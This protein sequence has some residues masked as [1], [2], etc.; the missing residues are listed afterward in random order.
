MNAFSRSFANSTSMAKKVVACSVA[1][2]LVASMSYF[3]LWGAPQAVADDTTVEVR[4][5]IAQDNVEVMVGDKKFTSQTKESYQASTSSDLNFTIEA[6]NSDTEFAVSYV[7]EA[8]AT[9]PEAQTMGSKQPGSGLVTTE[10]SENES[11]ASD[12]ELSAASSGVNMISS[13][14]SLVYAEEDIEP[15]AETAAILQ[16][17][18]TLESDAEIKAAPLTETTEQELVEDDETPMASSASD[19]I[20]KDD[21]GE[22][23]V[24]HAKVIISQGK[25]YTVA[26]AD[27]QKAAEEGSL[28]VVTIAATDSAVGNVGD[29]SQLESLLMSEND[30]TAVLSCDIVGKK[31]I[32]INGTKTLDLNGYTITGEEVSELFKVGVDAE[33]TITDAR[34]TAS[35]VERVDLRSEEASSKL[36]NPSTVPDTF[37]DY[38]GRKAV[39]DAERH[40]LTYYVT[41]SYLDR[42]AKGQS[43]E[44]LFEHVLDLSYA[45][46]IE[47]ENT[48]SLVKVEGGTL[49]IEGGRLTQAEGDHVVATK[50]GVVSMTGG[51]ITNSKGVNGAAINSSESE[52]TIGGN[53]IL[54]ANQA[55]RPTQ[56]SSDLARDE[57]ALGGAI[58]LDGGSLNITDNA[59]L[60]GNEA[61]STPLC[62]SKA[63]GFADERL[64]GAIYAKGGSK[65]EISGNAVLSG[66][67]A[68]ADGGAI[69]LCGKG[70]DKA[71]SQSKLTISGDVYITNNTALND[72][73][74]D[75]E[76]ATNP[77]GRCGGGGGIF[78]LGDVSVNSG[79]FTANKA[80]D[81]GGAIMI[82]Y[83][84]WEY[85][86]PTLQIKDCVV[87]SNYA[88]TSEGGG[89]QART[90]YAPH[91]NIDTDD[92]CILAG[93][94]T[95]NM[96]ATAFDYGGGALFLEQATSKLETRTTGM[97]VRYPVVEGNV[98]R[99]FGGGVGV[100]T[101]GVAVT[102][103]AAIFNNTALT[104]NATT[105][106]IEFG[107]RWLFEEKYGLK[108]IAK[109]KKVI[110]ENGVEK[111][112]SPADDFFCARESTVFNKMLGDADDSYYNWTGYTSGTVYKGSIYALREGANSSGNVLVVNN[113]ALASPPNALYKKDEQ[114]ADLHLPKGAIPDDDFEGYGVTVVVKNSTNKLFPTGTYNGMVESVKSVEPSF[115]EYDDKGQANPNFTKYAGFMNYKLKL[116]TA[117]QGNPM[118][119]THMK[120]TLSGAHTTSEPQPQDYDIYQI[121]DF[122]KAEGAFGKA[123]RLMFLKAEPS[124]NAK[125]AARSKAHVFIT[126][127]YSNTNGGGIACNDYIAIGR[128]PEVPGDSEESGDSDPKR[129]AALEITKTLDK[130]NKAN[131]SATA[132]FDVVGYEDK[133]AADY[134]VKDLEVYRNTISFTFAAGDDA[135]SQSRR[136]DNIPEGYYV[137]E[138]LSYSGDNFNN[139]QTAK[140]KKVVKVTAEEVA[141]DDGSDAS[142]SIS[143]V[144]EASVVKVAFNNI[145][146][147]ESYGTGV[148]N[149]YDKDD[150]EFSYTP[151]ANYEYRTRN[152]TT[153]EGR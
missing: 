1:A 18:E 66:N 70:G 110:D 68:N 96:T 29:W 25:T 97:L 87:A 111:L 153:E 107:D 151:D 149:H 126:G 58:Y 76:V 6:K 53:A 73:S 113:K 5:E 139:E 50:N 122:P 13:D 11:E 19:S 38:V 121:T 30:A 141:K 101:N 136:L 95:N 146:H 134:K 103:D 14:G 94:L 115:K 39:Y 128:D 91:N 82:T 92:S 23:P 102:A 100:C 77:R 145:Y 65:V 79:Y 28:I 9:A 17:K 71:C 43:E 148:V 133:D 135:Q 137:I 80:S 62:E 40:L 150:G 98:A 130:F 143:V 41:G 35:A 46:A 112:A 88:G 144:P 152:L 109:R 104:E 129:V 33:F 84:G 105:N 55:T 119:E 8:A 142:E 124:D 24:V 42:P 45:G 85:T 67:V 37:K 78:A 21:S 4:F 69:Y 7:T 99:G 138:E 52:I 132:V 123:D 61:G 16:E 20:G 22:Q 116:N 59:L 125:I 32:E 27:L 12:D 114:I 106:P 60:A 51:F 15:I 108:D 10:E 147:G 118:Q 93:Y 48:N 3:H 64:G 31:S 127:N 89:I 2:A 57:Q 86:A 117:P 131:G 49:K 44:F 36:P 54:A 120:V 34:K 74:K 63:S 81:G 75:H 83:I 26:R 56:I 47:G 140:N 72:K 90:S